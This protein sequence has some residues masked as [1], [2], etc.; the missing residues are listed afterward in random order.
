MHLYGY[1]Q[2]DLIVELHLDP[3]L[4]FFKLS[5]GLK[6][7]EKTLHAIYENYKME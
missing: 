3:G 6:N 5:Q 7:Y 4:F 1:Y 2:I